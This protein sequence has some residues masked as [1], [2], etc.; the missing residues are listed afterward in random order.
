MRQGSTISSWKDKVLFTPGPLTTSRTV[1]QAMLRDL[2]S[3]DSEFITI[4]RDIRDRLVTTGQANPAE[5]TTVILQ[6][7]GTYSLEAVAA[8]TIPAD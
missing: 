6:G 5:Y 2:G 3:R 4:V 1:K 8:S 7:A